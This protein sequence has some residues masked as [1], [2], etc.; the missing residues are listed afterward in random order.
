MKNFE[1]INGE[2][3]YKL[4]YSEKNFDKSLINKKY[5]LLWDIISEGNEFLEN[6]HNWAEYKF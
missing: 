1:D 6:I 2:K 4:Q 5:I 3:V